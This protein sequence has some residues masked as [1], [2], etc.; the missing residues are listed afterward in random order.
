MKHVCEDFLSFKFIYVYVI[1]LR[2]GNIKQKVERER[3]ST[4]THRSTQIK[5]KNK[6]I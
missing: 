4:V 6:K 3:S 5:G 1:I 2:H